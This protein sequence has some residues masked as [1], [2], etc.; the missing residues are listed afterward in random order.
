MTDKTDLAAEL[1]KRQRSWKY[2]GDAV[3]ERKR[4][5]RGRRAQ[6][7]RYVRVQAELLNSLFNGRWEWSDTS[8]VSARREGF[9]TVDLF[10]GCGGLTLG[11]DMA[12]FVSRLAVEVDPDASATYRRNFPSAYVWDDLVENLTDEQAT[13][14]LGESDTHIL[15]AG[16]P[17]QGFSVAGRRD[18]EDPRN[19]LFWQTIRFAKLLRP[20]FV[21]L[22][23]VPGIITMQK[24]H[25]FEMIREEFAKIGYPGMSTLVLEAADYG[26]AQYRPRAIFVANRFGYSNPYP[27]RVLEPADHVPIEAAIEDLASRSRDPSINHDWTHHS[28]Q[29]VKRISAVEPG[30]SL[31]DSY[32][33]AWKRQYEGVPS[34]TVK[35]NHGGTHI[36]YR[37]DRTLSAREMARLQSFPDSFLFEGRMKRV[38][39]QV[40][41]AVPPR[42]ANH[43]GL[44]LKPSLRSI[45]ARLAAG[46]LFDE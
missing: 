20:W 6:R 28:P 29:M 36:H 17:C 9:N 10:S 21:V 5:V 40:G 26:V 27:K 11:F 1:K 25:V 4:S 19:K 24:G 18:P 30:G 3:T 41:N 13:E 35:E 44:A 32:T 12:G 14:A 2:R 37:L 15:L 43:I 8:G 46:S 22:E 23:N 7:S 45:R 31:Y 16:F 33:D 39:F 34:M 42:L 38:M